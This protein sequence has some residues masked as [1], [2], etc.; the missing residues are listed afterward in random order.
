MIPKIIHYCWFGGADKDEKT[1]ECINSWNNVLHD[2]EII[3]WNETNFD[4]NINSFVREAYHSKKWAFVA[5]YVRLWA[6]CEYGGIYLDADVEVIKPFNDLLNLVAFTCFESTTYNN[7]PVIEAAVI[8]SQS[9]GKW[10]ET[11]LSIFDN[12]YFIIEEKNGLKQFNLEILP[13]RLMRCTKEKFD[14]VPI[15]NTTKCLCSDIVIFDYHWFSPKL[16]DNQK[17]EKNENTYAIHHFN[18]S[19]VDC[20]SYHQ[21]KRKYYNKFGKKLGLILFAIMHPIK[22]VR[23]YR[24]AKSS[25]QFS[26]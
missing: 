12:E 22:V 8:G 9:H 25:K 24:Y 13:I 4:I 14:I 20:P 11:M 1:V 2:Y 15:N 21:Q 16:P 6:L 26:K 7:S 18:N 19:W 17:I 5:D 23:L 3:E 10:I